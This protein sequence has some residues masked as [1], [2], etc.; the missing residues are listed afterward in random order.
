MS[1]SDISLSDGSELGDCS[2]LYHYT[3][4][5][6]NYDRARPFFTGT[7]VLVLVDQQHFVLTAAHVFESGFR[8]VA[9]GYLKGEQFRI[10]GADNMKILTAKPQSG[11][12]DA[13][14]AVYKDGLDLAIIEPTD[15]VL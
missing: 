12:G 9:F 8:K 7:G 5:I 1:T 15:E 14:R 6:L 13:Q 10:F 2:Q 11:A 4:P 3:V